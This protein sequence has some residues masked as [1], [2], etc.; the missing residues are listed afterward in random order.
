MSRKASVELI[1]TLDPSSGCT[2]CTDP[3]ISF[4]VVDAR[5]RVYEDEFPAV[6][7]REHFDGEVR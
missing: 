3:R 5:L 2:L 1:A 6:D 7:C 4:S